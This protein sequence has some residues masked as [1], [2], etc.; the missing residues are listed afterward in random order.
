MA[1][2]AST[3]IEEKNSQFGTCWITDEIENKKIKKI[4][5]IPNGWRLGR[6]NK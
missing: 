1:I 4:N 5:P 6:I 3:H 2:K